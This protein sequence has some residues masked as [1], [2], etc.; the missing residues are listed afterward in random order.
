MSAQTPRPGE[1]WESNLIG[2]VVLRTETGWAWPTG[3]PL[4]H[5]GVVRPV[6]DG[7]VAYSA[8]VVDRLRAELAESRKLAEAISDDRERE[9]EAKIKAYADRRPT[10]DE[11]VRDEPWRVLREVD[12][13]IR[14]HWNFDG[15]DSERLLALADEFERDHAERSRRDRLIERVSQAIASDDP[16]A[17]YVPSDAERIAEIAVDAV[18]AE[19]GDPQ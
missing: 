8:D 16:D 14:G 9:F 11:L 3:E 10:L 1:W 15:N 6:G 12:K 17:E 7:P 5:P 18:L 2:G 13:L 4:S 19:A